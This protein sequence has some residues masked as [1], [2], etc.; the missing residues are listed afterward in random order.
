MAC[1]D[2]VACPVADVQYLRGK[3][4]GQEGSQRVD[5]EVELRT[6]TAEPS[7]RELCLLT[8]HRRVSEGS[9]WL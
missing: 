5:G 7:L 1:V 3:E 2:Q 8:A 9:S 4:G 6:E